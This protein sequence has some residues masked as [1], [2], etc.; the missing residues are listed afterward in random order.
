[1]WERFADRE[2]RDPE[3]IVLGRQYPDNRTRIGAR[4]TDFIEIVSRPEVPDFFVVSVADCLPQLEAHWL[5]I[6]PETFRANPTQGWEPI[7]GRFDG[8]TFIGR[9]ELTTIKVDARDDA[10]VCSVQCTDEH[11]VEIQNFAEQP[12]EVVRYPFQRR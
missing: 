1:M 6:Q 12:I 5:V 8:L 2:M 3:R 4:D 10:T 7:G 11:S 9:E